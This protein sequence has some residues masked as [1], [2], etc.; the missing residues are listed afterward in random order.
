MLKVR[1]IY[2]LSSYLWNWR[3]SGAM[4]NGE[5]QTVSAYSP[6]RTVLHILWKCCQFG[7]SNKWKTKWI[8]CFPVPIHFP[9]QQITSRDQN[10]LSLALH[11]PHGL[12]AKCSGLTIAPKQTKFATDLK[13]IVT[14]DWLS[15]IRE[16]FSMQLEQAIIV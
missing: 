1:A 12:I 10:R 11:H 9:N 15:S 2:T 6:G 14:T 4:Y 5:P 3:T 8:N 7:E 16:S 13:M